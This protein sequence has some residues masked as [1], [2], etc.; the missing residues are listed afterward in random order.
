MNH[1]LA[2]TKFS[3]TYIHYNRAL[4]AVKLFLHKNAPDFVFFFTR[5][6]DTMNMAIFGKLEK[7][8]A[9]IAPQRLPV[10]TPAIARGEVS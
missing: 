8:P 6:D 1:R 2:N 4:R 7:E 3:S 10:F 5:T 9:A